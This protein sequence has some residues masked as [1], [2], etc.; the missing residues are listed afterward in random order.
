MGTS[1]AGEEIKPFATNEVRRLE[2]GF[3]VPLTAL[4]LFEELNRDD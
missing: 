4:E 2:S 1:E 3:D